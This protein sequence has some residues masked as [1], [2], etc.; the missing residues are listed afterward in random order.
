MKNKSILLNFFAGVA[1][2]SFIV[3]CSSTGYDKAADTA[4]SLT[5]S[6]DMIAKGSGLIDQSLA[7]LNDL[8]SNPQPD[9]RKQFKTFNSS[10]DDLGSTAKDVSSK[11]ESMKAQGTAYFEKWDHESAKIQNEDIR[12]RSVARKNE[13]AD[14]FGRIRADYEQTKA[15]FTPFMSDL[16]DVQ[17]FLSTDLTTGGLAAIKDVVAKANQHAVPLK[18]SLGELTSEFKGL[19]ASMSPTTG[20]AK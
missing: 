3:G 7:A 18:K 20:A 15:D 6:S 17:K 14:K 19:S 12:N 2:V 5:Q 1:A 8:V 4:T 16:R 10:V 13:V 11:A 9:L